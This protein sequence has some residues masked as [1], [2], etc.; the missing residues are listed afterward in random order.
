MA[1]N[2]S[3]KT[4]SPIEPRIQEFIES[5]Q[6]LVMRRKSDNMPLNISFSEAGL[7]WTAN[8]RRRLLYFKNAELRNVK[9]LVPE[10]TE[11]IWYPKFHALSKDGLEKSDN[12][13]IETFVPMNHTYPDG[14]LRTKHQVAEYR[15]VDKAL[16]LI[17]MEQGAVAGHHVTDATSAPGGGSSSEEGLVQEKHH[18]ETMVNS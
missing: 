5:Q 18:H 7:R 11:S 3:N 6:L 17:N 9:L 15:W 16:R 12:V 2:R 13:Y 14:N 4:L 8:N 10:S 1:N